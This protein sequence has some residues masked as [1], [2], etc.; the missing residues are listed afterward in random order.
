[1]EVF[2]RIR[3]KGGFPVS[4]I[5][6]N[7]AVN[8]AAYVLLGGIGKVYLSPDG[9]TA[10]LS[11]EY[12]HIYKNIRNNWIT[13]PSK[14]LTFSFKE[15]NYIACWKDVENLYQEDREAPVRL[16]KLNH[17]AVNPKPLQRQSIELVAKIFHEKT[18]A[19]MSSKDLKTKLNFSEG[20]ALLRL[21]H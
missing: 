3:D 10:F 9:H 15:K 13:E 5:S 21:F 16:T 7:C 4:F 20:T 17:T 14:E 2:Y 1:M 12:D 11:H 8:K 6:D 18:I 19:A